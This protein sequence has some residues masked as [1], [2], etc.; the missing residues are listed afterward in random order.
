MKLLVCNFGD[1]LV[2]VYDRG[3]DPWFVAKDACAVLGLA[4]NRQAVAGLDEDEISN[5]TTSDTRAAGGSVGDPDISVPNRGLTIISESGLYALIF[6]SRKPQAKAFRK[7]VTSEV[8]PALR[9]TGTYS[10]G[11]E[12]VVPE[13]PR[14]TVLQFLN[15]VAPGVWRMSHASQIGQIAR[16]WSHNLGCPPRRGPD[17]TLGEHCRMFPLPVLSAAYRSV[18]AECAHF[19]GQTDLPVLLT[20]EEVM[21]VTEN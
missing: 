18:R 16:K 1:S 11:V 10:L 14:L 8:L 12:Q 9:K 13:V 6:K 3:G 20:R 21:P 5:V 19:Y 15:A 4:N 2:R 17:E 7:W